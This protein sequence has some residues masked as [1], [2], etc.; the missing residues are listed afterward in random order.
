M[1]NAKPRKPTQYTIEDQQ[2]AMLLL[3]YNNGNRKRTERET[4][5]SRKTLGVWDDAL[6]DDERADLVS[7]VNETLE[8]KLSRIVSRL[9]DRLDQGLD[10]LAIGQI[11]VA[12]GI[13]V[14]KLRLLRGESTDNSAVHI[15]PDPASLAAELDQLLAELPK[16]RPFDPAK[17]AL[18]LPVAELD[19]IMQQVTDHREA[20]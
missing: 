14:D 1:T 19:E 2:K 20:E 13:C 7:R 15:S 16:E 11:P 17:R 10:T 8:P 3:T 18:S 9:A 12:L 6:T 5:I 4:G